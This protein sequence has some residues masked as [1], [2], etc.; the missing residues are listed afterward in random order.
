MFLT[1]SPTRWERMLRQPLARRME[2]A[3]DEFTGFLE[4]YYA[5]TGEGAGLR[6]A[7]PSPGFLEELRAAVEALPDVVKRLLEPRLL[8]VFFVGGLRS[9]AVMDLVAYA[10]GDILGAA[11]AIDEQAFAGFRAN[12]WATQRENEPFA[13]SGRMR[14]DV[15][16]DPD[17][18]RATALQYILLHEFGHVL[19]SASDAMPD[20]WSERIPAERVGPGSF[21]AI[22]WE[23]DEAGSLVPKADQDFPLRAALRFYE[24]PRLEGE[25]ISAVYEGLDRTAF[26]TTYAATNANEDFAES[27]ATYAHAVLLGKPYDCA[28]YRDG[29]RIALHGGFWNTPRSREKAA[30][31]ER[32]LARAPAA[33]PRQVQ[34]VQA[35]RL[36]QEI[37]DQARTRFLGLAPFLRLNIESGD[38]RH[39]AQSLLT[40]ASEERGNAALW[41]NLATAFFCLGE[42][43]V[44][45]NIQHQALLLGRVFHLPA[46]VRPARLRVLMLAAPGDLAENT[47]LDCLL[48]TSAVDLT[49]YY[50][51]A[52]APVPPEPIDHDLLLVGMS[53][54][55]GN[56][57]LLA[58]LEAALADWDRPVVNPPGHIPNVERRRASVLLQGAP[59]LQM[60]L[61]HRA[62]RA[63]L[64]AVAA[65]VAPLESL[66]GDSR[67]PVIVRPA[68]SHAGHGLEKI[69]DAPGL[70]S[71]LAARRDDD[72]Y[73]SNF[74]DYRGA[75]G[76]FRKFRVAFVAGRPFACHMAV[77]SHW[78]IHYVNAGMFADEDKRAEEA[79]FMAGFDGFAQRHGPAL[80]A[81]A[82]RCGL[83]Y[84][85]MDCAES[86]EGEL[87][88]FEIDHAM[89][90]HAMDP[91]D[92]FPHKREHILKLQDAVEDFLHGV[93]ARGAAAPRRWVS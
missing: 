83:D 40:A 38:M 35:A 77:S 55:D 61:T 11:V 64:E 80:K 54:T 82:G 56:R 75:D 24:T 22:G 51:M 25:Q 71:Y 62:A 16:I 53:E 69:D 65:G 78:M 14:L 36:C 47:P 74:I 5:A 79:A 81:I 57:A 90:V 60:P 41:M 44:G 4:R 33:F 68:G 88:V 45:L 18:A 21:A 70:A 67:F 10:N 46:A 1:G 32:F 29:E 34:H 58:A 13:A 66:G 72:F 48:E 52:D 20:W 85:A 7:E 37:V 8:G 91:E 87:L 42:R 43:E 27:F 93:Q 9:S 2:P 19:A 15:L 12:D 17:D 6:A 39:A 76:L 92:L 26:P 50:A 89:V 28:V 86:R 73:L 3:S 84:F 63:R 49:V 31:L 30:F 59:G 23:L